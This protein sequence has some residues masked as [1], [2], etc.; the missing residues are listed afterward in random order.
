M[1]NARNTK[2]LVIYLS[3]VFV[4]CMLVGGKI[5]KNALAQ[6]L[7]LF[8]EERNEELMPILSIRMG[9]EE[10]KVCAL[11]DADKENE[12]Y[13]FLP[14][15]VAYE[16]IKIINH[17]MMNFC[18]DEKEIMYL[19]NA[20]LYEE[21]KQKL[22]CLTSTDET[23]DNTVMFHFLEAGSVPTVFIE[24]D[25][26]LS[27]NIKDK[28][29]KTSGRLYTY[30]SAANCQLK[31]GI[32]FKGH[33]N[34]SFV[35]NEKKS[36]NIKFNH[37][38]S[39]LGLARGREYVALS[40]AQDV[41]YMRNKIV[42]DMA[43]EVGFF[44]T[45][46]GEY[47]NLYI[48]SEYMGLYLMTE[49]I[50]VSEERVTTDTADLSMAYEEA[51][52][53]HYDTPEEKGYIFPETAEIPLEI[54]YLFKE[55][56]EDDGRYDDVR[57]GFIA[58]KES[59]FQVIY[60][61]YVSKQQITGLRTFME[62]LLNGIKNEEG[63]CEDAVGNSVHYSEVIDLDSFLKKYLI[64]E[65]SKNYDGNVRSSYYYINSF[66]E[67]VKIFAGPVWDYD[68]A[69]GN[70][71]NSVEWNNPQ[72]IV[73]LRP[74]LDLREEFKEAAI[75]YYAVYFAPYLE[76]KVELQIREYVE[77]IRDSAEMDQIRWKGNPM[78]KSTFDEG[79]ENLI[80]F[81]NVR[82]QFLDDVWI[83]GKVYH[84]VNFVDGDKVIKNVYVEDGDKLEEYI[85][86]IEGKAFVGWYNESMEEELD[87]SIGIKDSTAFWA[88]WE[89]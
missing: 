55:D 47:A 29:K 25:D 10:K 75:Q 36:W 77:Y 12:F 2:K 33:G 41:S 66:D 30:D 32:Q 43:E 16:N 71:Q 21:E 42:F 7:F 51:A 83:Q 27:E 9:D 34:S 31:G 88:K 76:K 15:G 85:P 80:S 61:Q 79:I 40:N 59:M 14:A 39:L 26:E 6:N 81:I 65:I 23:K 89:E 46:Q 70:C 82:K 74:G 38:V 8:L 68:L 73:K 56:T 44:Y 63:Y 3:I 50:E 54:S 22:L 37:E 53:Q 45:P 48:N 4:F 84:R 1:R 11:K 5:V 69:F 58:N 60:P 35:K 64:E 57:N 78:W 72:G 19:E 13:F 86:V 20:V 28:T 67:N 87:Y 49:K 24:L 17:T 52:L 62:N 18:Q